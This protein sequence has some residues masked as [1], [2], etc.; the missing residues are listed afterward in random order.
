MRWWS[1]APRNGTSS[2]TS[3]RSTLELD[4]AELE[5]LNQVRFR[6][7]YIGLSL[8]EPKAQFRPR[9]FLSPGDWGQWKGELRRPSVEV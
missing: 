8:V 5:R 2:T 4:A 7:P 6:V 1:G 9:P 3:P